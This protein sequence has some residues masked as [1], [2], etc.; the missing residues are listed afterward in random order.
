[1]KH[2]LINLYD[3]DFARLEDILVA[4]Y[5]DALEFGHDEDAALINLV[6]TQLQR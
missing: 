3:L 1:M 2:V 4:A 5:N 6:M